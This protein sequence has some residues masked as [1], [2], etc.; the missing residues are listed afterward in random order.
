MFIIESISVNE[1]PEIWCVV[2]SFE[3]Y[4]GILWNAAVT[5]NSSAIFWTE[6][7]FG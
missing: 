3:T 1:S 4:T 6:N 2:D 5:E 7:S